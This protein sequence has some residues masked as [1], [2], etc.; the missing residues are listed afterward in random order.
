M[1]LFTDKEG[2]PFPPISRGTESGEAIN[3]VA[4]AGSWIGISTRQ[5]V[6]FWPLA[7]TPGH[8]KLVVSPFGAHGITSTGSW[9]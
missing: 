1:L 7:G 9:L 2:R 4:R 3:G 8:T 5:E 6:N